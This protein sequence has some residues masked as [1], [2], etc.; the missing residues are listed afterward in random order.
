MGMDTQT[1]RAMTFTTLIVAN[2]SL[3]LT[4]ASWSRSIIAT[5]RSKN[6]A[7]WWV[8][9]GAFVFLGLVLYVPF[10]SQLFRFKHLTPRRSPSCAARGLASV[11]WFELPKLIM[12]HRGKTLLQP[13][14][15]CPLPPW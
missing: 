2:L 6:Q 8:V 1:S 3:I 14:P 15:T 12:A 7:M 10:L 4:N 13:T 9:G 5:L 11:V